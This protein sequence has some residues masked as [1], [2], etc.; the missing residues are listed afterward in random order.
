MRQSV[1]GVPCCQNSGERDN[2]LNPFPREVV[3]RTSK[4][5]VH[6]PRSDCEFQLRFR[7]DVLR[8]D[9]HCLNYLGKPRIE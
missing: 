3:D 9:V 8:T 6:N 5:G 1:K 4:G 7:S 2:H